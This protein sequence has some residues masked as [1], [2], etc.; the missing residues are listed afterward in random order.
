[1][2]RPI[3]G[4]PRWNKR[5]GMWEARVTPVEGGPRHV[6]PM[7]GIAEDDRAGAAALAVRLA[8]HA[9]KVGAV[10]VDSTET[11]SE[12][13][14][15]YF[16]WR[17]TRPRAESIADRRARVAKWVIPHIGACPMAT[18]TSDEIRA[19]VRSLD[20]AVKGNAISWKTAL[21]VWGEVT[22]AF[23]DACELNVDAL[24][25]RQDN[26]VERVRGP[27]RGDVRS[28][29][30]LRPGELVALLGCAAVPLR[31][32][33]LYAVAAYTGLRV[34]ELRGLRVGDVSLGA[35]QV[36]VV[37]QASATHV[38][39]ARTKTGRARAV[40]IEASLAPLLAVLVTDR[41]AGAPLLD[42]KNEPHAQLVR[43][44]LQKAGCTREALFADDAM[45]APFVFH[46]FRDTC[47]THMAV[48]RDPPQ[49]IQWRAGHTTPAMTERYI[50]EARHQAGPGFG[51][52]F[53][54]LP[55][56]LTAPVAI[57]QGF[58]P[59]TQFRPGN[60]EKIAT[61][62]GIEDVSSAS[63]FVSEERV[64]SE[65]TAV[66]DMGERSNCDATRHTESEVLLGA[67]DAAAR[68]G[69]FDVVAQLA[70]Q[71]EARQLATAGNV[72]V[73]GA[74]RAR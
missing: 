25:V 29:P 3:T 11:V 41:P 36:S 24:R 64:I 14:V 72:V 58:G 31:R 61:P 69:R 2:A 27:E 8:H 19:V 65:E 17:E 59:G 68:A 40:P 21:N 45:R 16:E 51:H 20:D 42:I 57:G 35:G 1:M 30:F 12:W 74:K 7:P 13:F 55:E 70:R 67:L 33:Q 62:T 73:L 37:R 39:K 48:R 50:A 54:A 49:D 6:V 28:K 60:T 71:L 43:G 22:K 63:S 18:V 10:R 23:A 53:P 26:P 9:R 46:N 44:D 4:A 32:R 52:P 5:R 47:L 66:A 56:A 34:G 15:R 38:V